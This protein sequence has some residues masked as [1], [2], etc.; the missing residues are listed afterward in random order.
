MQK[1][2]RRALVVVRKRRWRIV[3]LESQG[4]HELVTLCGAEPVN[5]AATRRILTPFDDVEPVAPRDRPCRVGVRRWRSACR[6]LVAEAA[7]PWGLRAARGA[8]IDLLPY[9]LE[10]ALAVVRG[11]GSR[12][13]LADDVGLGKTVQAALVIAELGARHAVS[14]T[15]VLAPAGLREQW[16][17][18]L[19]DR[20][21]LSPAIVDMDEI[22]RRAAALPPGVNPWQTVPLAVASMDYVKRPEVLPAVAACAWDLLVVDE[23]HNVARAS[24]RRDAA[25]VLASRAAFVVLTTA[26]P[27]NGDRDAFRSLCALGAAGDDDHVLFFRRTRRDVRS[28][29]KR[30]IHRVRV[31]ST[32][33]EARMHALLARYLRAVRRERGD[34]TALAAATLRKRAFSSARALALSVRRR[35]ATLDASPGMATGEIVQLV[36]PLDDRGGELDASDQTPPW[37]ADLGLSDRA[38][39]RRL[40][41]RLAIAAVDA[42]RA[43]SKVALLRRLLRRV[44]EPVLI[45]TEYRDTLE[46]LRASLAPGALVL[47][48]GLNRQERAAAVRAFT[49]GEAT[50]LL[51]TDAAGE[52]LNL[53]PAC[54][55]VVNLE[56]PWNPMRLEQRIGRVDRIGQARVVHAFHLVAGDTP[57]TL[58]WERLQRRVALAAYDAGAANPMG[59]A[60]E[61]AVA[62]LVATGSEDPDDALD[63]PVAP[64]GLHAPDLTLESVCDAARLEAAR[65]RTRQGDDR[66]RVELEAS[67]PWIARTRVNP[68]RAALGRRLLTIYGVDL[69]D[70]AG[71]IVA[72]TIVPLLGGVAGGDQ[73]FTGKLCQSDRLRKYA[74]DAARRWIEDAVQIH[75]SFV[76][77]CL[78][79]ARFMGAH[80]EPLAAQHQIGLFDRRALRAAEAG[81]SRERD[82]ADVRRLRVAAHERAAHIQATARLLL[83]LT[84]EP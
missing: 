38:L 74:E 24:D 49:R 20:L 11:L 80:T 72:S 60:E 62:R 59:D 16:R 68:T 55:M 32:P 81:E 42:G 21:G 3:E 84:P 61:H 31:R 52:G 28:G 78:A 77:M 5:H 64:G 70:G 67:A 19:R 36:L 14:R 75:G 10:P 40:L 12:I 1:L 69:E 22:S 54:R 53:H 30:R 50:V 63:Q 65:Q 34:R 18:E 8:R 26:T 23:A 7:P 33:A 6:A 48:G 56:L 43:E 51:A 45:F 2:Q 73:E 35:L 13:L 82:S 71:H 29:A 41:A 47:H 79:R 4:D 17:D 15:L 83:M 39:E 27:H 9:Q 76:Q 25:R 37:H 57:E 58:V 46:H 66:R 44:R